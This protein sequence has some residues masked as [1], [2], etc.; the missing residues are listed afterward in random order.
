MHMPL[1]NACTEAAAS[2]VLSATVI[3][4]LCTFTP[5]FATGSENCLSED[6]ASTGSMRWIRCLDMEKWWFSLYLLSPV[7]IAVLVYPFISLSAAQQC[8]GVQ[9]G[10]LVLS[11]CWCSDGVLTLCG[12]GLPQ[13]PSINSSPWVHWAP[14]PVP[15]Y[16]G[17]WWG[18]VIISCGPEF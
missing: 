11:R 4:P 15:S 8:L 13:W 14:L 9:L 18:L 1:Q 17:G 16:G 6:V 2:I 12:Y 5:V 3:V 7:G 10:C